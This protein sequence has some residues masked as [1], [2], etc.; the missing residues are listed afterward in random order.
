MAELLVHRLAVSR[1]PQVS[2]AA[3]GYAGCCARGTGLF[4]HRIGRADHA[5]T[6]V[7][8]HCRAIKANWGRITRLVALAITDKRFEDFHGDSK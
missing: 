6:F 7:V 2:N 8:G 4:W 3:L 1:Y 5:V